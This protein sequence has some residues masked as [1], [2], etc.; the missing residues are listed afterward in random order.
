MFVNFERNNDYIFTYK[1]QQKVVE[2][3][4]CS[5]NKK[6]KEKNEPTKTQSKKQRNDRACIT[7]TEKTTSNM[8]KKRE[9]LTKRTKMIRIYECRS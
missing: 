2:I 6:K 8:K 4:S 1:Q 7:Q 9:C 5:K 3:N